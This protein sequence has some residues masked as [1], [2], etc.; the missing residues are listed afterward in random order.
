[1]NKTIDEK[2]IGIGKAFGINGEF[3]CSSQ[4]TSGHINSTY[5]AQFKIDG[6]IEKYLVQKINTHVFKDPDGLMQNITGVTSYLRKKTKENDG[7]PDRETLTFLK[8]TNGKYYYEDGDS[9]WR[10]YRFVDNTM[11]YD[12]IENKELFE[13][14]GRSFGRFQNLL[15]DYPSESLKETIP[16]F[17]NTPKRLQT[18]EDAYNDN[19]VNR[20]S[21]VKEEFAFAMERR[22]RAGRALELLNEGKIPLRVTHND[23]KINNILFDEKTNKGICIIDLDTIMPGLSLYDFGDAIRSGAATALEDEEDLSKVG[24]S[25]ELYESYVRGYLSSCASSLTKDEV[26]NLPYGAWLMTFEC[27]SRFLTDYLQGD[28]YFKVSKPN[29]NL[30]RA[31]NQYQMVR[32]IEENEQALKDITMRVYTEYVK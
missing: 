15:S 30:I 5:L 3:V 31:R 27:G 13:D 18:L 6:K 21:E 25:L 4:F 7:D 19:I 16:N 2:L 23:T 29:H 24:V 26:E 22:E 1:M 17:H 12:L 9:C 10:I 8:A 32:K 11:T 14:S 20:A 28:T